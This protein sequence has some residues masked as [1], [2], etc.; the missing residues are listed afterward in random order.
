MTSATNPR[1]SRL[2]VAAVGLLLLLSSACEEEADPQLLRA[3]EE[4]RALEDT[5][6]ALA[7]SG[8]DDPDELAEYVGEVMAKARV[9]RDAAEETDEERLKE[10]A[11]R[12]VDKVSIQMAVN[13]LETRDPRAA[14][15]P[16]AQTVVE[17]RSVC[18]AQRA[19][20]G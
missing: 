18:D 2:R 12:A 15:Q 20:P 8:T 6:L 4:V 3:C 19:Y 1:T 13:A 9:V 17:M 10:L 11:Q 7:A 16:M 14:A 5:V